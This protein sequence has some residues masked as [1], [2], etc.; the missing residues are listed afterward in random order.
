[1]E[2]DFEFC[3]IAPE[4]YAAGQKSETYW[5]GVLKRFLASRV[6]LA[7]LIAVLL[8]TALAVFAPMFSQYTFDEI[9]QVETDGTTYT[10]DGL[11]PSF[12]VQASEE[13]GEVFAGRRFLFGTDN[14]GRDLWTRTWRGAR[15]SL[16]IAFVSL[17]I[18]V[19]IGM[20]YG[21]I[22]GYIGGRTDNIMQHITE[23]IYSIPTLVIIAVLAIF[24][25]K[26]IGMIVASLVISGWIPMHQITRA[27][28]I[29]IK[30]ME[31][32]KASRT[33]GT[34]TFH[35]MFKTIL[36]NTL[37]PIITQVMFSVPTAIF[38]EAF[39]SF[40]GF[41]IRVP[42]CSIGSLIETG[43]ENIVSHPYQILPPLAVL[44]VLILG[45]NAIGSAL[46][47]AFQPGMAQM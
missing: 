41:G 45:F 25:P 31:Y 6:A 24:I 44:V 1:M 27:Q 14:L 34:S 18:N 19:V 32:V 43:F 47:E 28:V 3:G 36:P 39:L 9:I 16:I 30:N 46:K 21:T 38:T 4:T 40:V 42:D 23:I 2:H 29:K 22:A 10:A 13:K 5:M 15:V 33:L 11:A 37:G 17:V 8:V 12:S 26:G 35:I 7:G 20:I